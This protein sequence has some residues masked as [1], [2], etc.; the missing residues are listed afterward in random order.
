M[1]SEL[2][3][4]AIS[5]DDFPVDIGFPV[6]RHNDLIVKSDSGADVSRYA[7]DDVADGKG[8]CFVGFDDEV[9]LALG[10]EGSIFQSQ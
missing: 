1:V 8:G 4:Y 2:V 6:G 9:F 7:V 5:G 3:E 10:N